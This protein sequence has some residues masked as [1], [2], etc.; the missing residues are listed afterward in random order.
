MEGQEI[1]IGG[2]TLRVSSGLAFWSKTGKSFAGIRSL[3]VAFTGCN[4]VTSCV[5]PAT[6]NVVWPFLEMMMTNMFWM[7]CEYPTCIMPFN[8]TQ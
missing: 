2:L 6:A 1:G 3:S 5:L 8:T 7:Y 4:Y